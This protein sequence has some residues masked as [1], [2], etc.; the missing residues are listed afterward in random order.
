[1]TPG[2]DAQRKE[3]DVARKVSKLRK[4]RMKTN[5]YEEGDEPDRKDVRLLMSTFADDPASRFLEYSPR[6]VG[7]SAVNFGDSGQNESPGG[8]APALPLPRS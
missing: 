2:G 5:R 8:G 3:E 1:M 7:S 4:R 6:P